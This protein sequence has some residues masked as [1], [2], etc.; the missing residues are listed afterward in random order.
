MRPDLLPARVRFW[1]LGG[2]PY[3][4]VY[5]AHRTPAQVLR[6]LHMARG[7]PLLLADWPGL[8]GEDP[9]TQ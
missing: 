4:L 1:T 8:S 5:D 2:L 3:L 7:L 6:V 9:P